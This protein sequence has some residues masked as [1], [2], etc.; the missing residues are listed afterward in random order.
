MCDEA[1]FVECL[2]KR[3]KD[4]F[5]LEKL[6]GIFKAI[7]T[8]LKGKPKSNLLQ[9]YKARYDTLSPGRRQ[10]VCRGLEGLLSSFTDK[11]ANATSSKEMVDNLTQNE[12]YLLQ[13]AFVD[14]L[15]DTTAKHL[16]RKQIRRTLNGI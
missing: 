5:A 2:E 15:I 12:I 16:A 13:A 11:V 14:W 4:I 7:R 1:L 6:L 3:A 9:L 8:D 10:G